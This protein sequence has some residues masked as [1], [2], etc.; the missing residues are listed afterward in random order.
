MAKEIKEGIV[1]ALSCH[2]NK[3]QKVLKAGDKIT[4][5]DD[6]NFDELVEK[7][8]VKLVKEE[9]PKAPEKEETPEKEEVKEE[10]PKAK[11]AAPKK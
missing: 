4:E 2:A 9:K 6:S 1:I 3:I 10:K 11:K 8:Y 5:Q 7:G